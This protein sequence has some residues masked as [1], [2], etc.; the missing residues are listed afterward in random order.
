MKLN[1]SLDFKQL[2]PLVMAR[3]SVVLW[4]FLLSVILAEGLIIKSSVDKILTATNVSEYAG[5]QLTR[6]NFGVYDDIEKR[7]SEN[8]KFVPSEVSNK[9]PFGLPIKVKE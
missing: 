5:A 1:F 8:L 7:L 9:D 2:M 6:V 4:I 3:F